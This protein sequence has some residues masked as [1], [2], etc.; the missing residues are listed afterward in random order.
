TPDRAGPVLNF[1]GGKDREPQAA[2]SS[3]SSIVNSSLRILKR[4]SGV[5]DCDEL[6]HELEAARKNMA[7]F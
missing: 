2:L 1:R 4:D 5:R 7:R 6:G 3:A